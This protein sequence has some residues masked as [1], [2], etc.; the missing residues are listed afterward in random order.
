MLFLSNLWV[1][2]AATLAVC[3]IR[4]PFFVWRPDS[5]SASLAADSYR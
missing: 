2:G 3:R 1:A 5:D 4:F